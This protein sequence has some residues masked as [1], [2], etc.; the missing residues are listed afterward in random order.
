MDGRDGT[1]SKSFHPGLRLEDKWNQ[2]QMLKVMAP[3]P[4]TIAFDAEDM[5]GADRFI[6]RKKKWF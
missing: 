3:M 6:E 5:V 4:E 1:L 2:Y